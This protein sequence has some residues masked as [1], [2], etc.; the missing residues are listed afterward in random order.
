M[1]TDQELMIKIE[2]LLKNYQGSGEDLYKA[3]GMVVVGRFMGSRAI[4]LIV[5]R[6]VWSLS[7]KLFGDLTHIMPERGKYAGKSVGLA[8]A[9]KLGGYWDFIKGATDAMPLEDRKKLSN[10]TNM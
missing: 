7:T 1:M 4:R 5:P 8:I 2:D 9:D 10:E 6:R 3:V